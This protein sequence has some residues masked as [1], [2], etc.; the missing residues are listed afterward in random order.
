MNLTCSSGQPCFLTETMASWAFGLH[1]VT[2]R[3]VK[4][5]AW[6][7]SRLPLFYLTLSLNLCGD[8]FMRRFKQRQPPI[9]DFLNLH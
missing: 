3:L 1:V 8:K 5:L 4:K 6:F 7:P 9:F 2:V